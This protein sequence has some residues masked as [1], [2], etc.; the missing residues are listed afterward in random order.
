M[1]CGARCRRSRCIT[2]H[3]HK[4]CESTVRY[5]AQLHS[6]RQVLTDDDVLEQILKAILLFAAKHGLA[7]A[8]SAQAIALDEVDT[9][10][11]TDTAIR[12]ALQARQPAAQHAC[13]HASCCL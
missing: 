8:D 5:R 12:H 9:M 10:D 3:R 4:R 7:D 13:M 2:C 11:I 1:G 6:Y